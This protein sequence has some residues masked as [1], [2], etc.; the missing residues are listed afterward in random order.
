MIRKYNKIKFVGNPTNNRIIRCERVMF[1]NKH[2]DYICGRFNR[3][4]LPSISSDEINQLKY[5]RTFVFLNTKIDDKIYMNFYKYCVLNIIDFDVAVSEYKDMIK[6]HSDI[7]YTECYY[8]TIKIVY[9]EYKFS[10]RFNI[11]LYDKSFHKHLDEKLKDISKVWLDD[12]NSQSLKADF[13]NTLNNANLS[14]ESLAMS[15]D[16]DIT[17]V[18]KYMNNMNIFIRYDNIEYLEQ[19]N[20]YVNGK[21]V[22]VGKPRKVIIDKQPYVEYVIEKQVKY[23][24]SKPNELFSIDDV[25]NGCNYYS[26]YYSETITIEKDVVGKWIKLN[27]YYMRMIKS[28]ID[29]FNSKKEKIIR[30]NKVALIY[31]ILSINDS[32]ESGEKIV[33]S[34]NRD[35]KIVISSFFGEEFMGDY[36]LGDYNPK[37]YQKY[38]MDAELGDDDLGVDEFDF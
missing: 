19:T 13:F 23:L 34:R 38:D 20:K 30:Q 21:I 2:D 37:Y 25:I 31:S 27:K 17:S 10:K 32:G 33:Y 24:L 5:L 22:G 7:L 12:A 14:Y 1:K 36:S 3:V 28:H 9:N 15:N 26:E 29:I 8:E 4:K 35:G 6:T 18:E 16:L 11:N